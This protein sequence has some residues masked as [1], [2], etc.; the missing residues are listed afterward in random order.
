MSQCQEKGIQ[1]WNRTCDNPKPKN[2]G[3]ECVGSSSEERSCVG[4]GGTHLG[5]KHFIKFERTV[6]G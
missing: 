3:L 6:F 2:G 4:Q 1:R 5:K